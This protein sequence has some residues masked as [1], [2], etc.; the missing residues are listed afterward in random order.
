MFYNTYRATKSAIRKRQLSGTHTNSFINPKERLLNQHKREKLKNLL[1]TK[2]IQKYNIKNPEEILEP[3]ISKFIQ[4]EKLNDT[5][6][7]RLD[8]KI[9]NI[10]K[11]KS[12]KDNL[13]TKFTQS[14][15]GIDSNQN[16]EQKE[17]KIGNLYG[18]TGGNYA[19]NVYDQEGLS[20]CLSTFQGG[21][22]QRYV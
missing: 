2:F 12:A 16:D 17:I 3:V 22:Q 9:Q 5:D 11:N 1:I 7:K 8:I 10:I 18:F 19:G 20:P 6:L 14:L 15:Q 13:K 4:S 21:N